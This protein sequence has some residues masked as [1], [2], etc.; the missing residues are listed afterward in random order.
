MT[1]ADQFEVIV[2]GGG[3][4]GLAAGYY[5]AKAGLQFVILDAHARTGDSWRRRWDSLRLFTPARINGLPG[6]PYPAPP[7]AVVTKDEIANYLESY[8]QKFGLPIRHG[9][10]V[11]SLMREDRRFVASAGPT[12]IR[13]DQVVVATGSYPTPHLPAFASDLDSG[14]AQFHSTEYRNPSQLQGDVLVVGAGNSGAEIALEAAQGHKT[15]LSGRKTGQVPYPVIFSR[16]MWWFGHLVLSRSTPIGRRMAAA[17]ESGRGQPLVRVKP[18]DLAAAGIE[19]VPKVAGVQGG[20]PRLED[21][22]V[23]DVQTVIWCTGFDHTYPW[24]KLPISDDS[25][26]VRHTRGVVDSEP[27][28][29][30][31]GLPFQHRL[32]SSLIGGVGED[33]KYVIEKIVA[34]RSRA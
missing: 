17:Q 29:D 8:A 12:R 25:G 5:L 3:Q 22:R 23:L 24:I 2:I 32:S 1:E 20:K 6:M 28:L 11:D 33:A 18:Q 9:V 26:H 34:K 13:A 30:F 14:I 7:G 15:F 31:V 16:P 21:G 27:G 19:R 4:S 10:R